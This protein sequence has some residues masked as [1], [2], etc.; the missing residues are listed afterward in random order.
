MLYEIAK[1]LDILKGDCWHD[2]EGFKLLNLL[3]PHINVPLKQIIKEL[4][5]LRSQLVPYVVL[6]PGSEIRSPSQIT[7]CQVKH[8]TSGHS[9]WTCLRQI[10]DF[11][12]NAHVVAQFYSL[13]IDQ[14]EGHVVVEHRIH[15]LNP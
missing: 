10:L 4:N 6:L 2:F 11:E 9:G 15:I 8:S 13:S 3:K 7:G 1:A 12:E 14:A 5:L